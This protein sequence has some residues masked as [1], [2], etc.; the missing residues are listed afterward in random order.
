M[1]VWKF[2]LEKVN[3]LQAHGS[4]V[5]RMRISYDNKFLFSAG[6][7]GSLMIMDIKDKDPRG[8][9]LKEREVSVIDKFSEEILTEIERHAC[10]HVVLTGGEPML[11]AET[12]PLCED[13]HRRGPNSQWIAKEAGPREPGCHKRLGT[14]QG[15]CAWYVDDVAV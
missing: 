2:P 13:L 11:F 1:Q 14:R 3:E 12:V 4:P 15:L 10:T 7:D 8:G 9:N 5:T 6:K